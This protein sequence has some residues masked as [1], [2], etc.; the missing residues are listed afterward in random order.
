MPVIERDEEIR[1]GQEPQKVAERPIFWQRP[2]AQR[3]ITALIVCFGLF[4]L[5]FGIAY[6][7]AAR[8]IDDR[9]AAGPFAD[10]LDVFGAPKRNSADDPGAT[11]PP[12]LIA[13]TSGNRE[14]RRLV[15]FNQIPPRLIHAVLSVED[16]NF[17]DHSGFDLPRMVK[18]AYVDMKS[19]RKDQGASTLTMQMV[20][21]FWLQ[22]DKRWKRKLQEI[23][24]TL[25]VEEKLSKQQIFEF[26]ANQVYLG[27]RD[28]FSINGFAEGAHAYFGKDLAQLTDGEAAMLAGLVQRPSY[29]N[30][31]RYPERARYR[32]DMVLGLMYRN[33]YLDNA[34]YQAA[35]QEPLALHLEKAVDG[36][37]F[38]FVDMVRDEV[39]NK[40]GDDAKDARRVF[41]SLD[42]DLQAAAEAAVHN[43]MAHVDALL[44]GRRDV[45]PGEPQVALVALDPRTGEVKAL[46]G[47]RDYRTSQL[48]HATAMRQPGSAFKP[49]VYAAALSTAVE[50]GHEVLTPSSIVADEP[51]RIHFGGK[52]YEP[53]NYHGGTSGNV[54]LRYAL[55]H[56]LNLATVSLASEV[57]YDRVVRTAL[58][59]GWDNGIRA[60]PAVALGAYEATPMEVAGAYTTFVNYGGYVAPSLVSEVQSA[61]G[62]VLYR[63]TP[64]M[65][66]ALDPRVSYLMVTM[67]QDVL[68][69][70]TGAGVWSYGLTQP[71]AGK[72]GTSR[73]GWFAGFTSELVCVV[74]VGFDDNR[75]LNLEGAKSAL[76]IWAEFMSRAGKLAPYRNATPFRA[77]AGIVARQICSDS[78]EL[79]GP[80]CTNVH[81][82][83]FIAGTEPLKQCEMHTAPPAPPPLVIDPRAPQMIIGNQHDRQ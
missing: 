53:H 58:R 33:G 76:P 30:P 73:D 12:Q 62:R 25:R 71:A 7:R 81:S 64:E 44:R 15:K 60:T 32:R 77:P 66:N 75:D 80:Y 1:T 52:D 61:D 16:K 79:A 50:G 5:L 47:G 27:R 37:R 6:V 23:L 57:G 68:R 29:Y 31:V 3:A 34:A 70:G 26:Y 72:T 59:M 17:F 28:T 11:G 18:A 82:D 35:L 14:R 41:T 19:G 42:R 69:S 8:L 20:R 4:T 39:E 21:N 48:N 2:F 45:P 13:N 74:W 43:G 78:G 49:V 65:K 36:S 51:M 54:T 38:Y 9:L 46:V 67:L 56:S 22:P 40:L 10:T 24:L 63:H 83:S 55:A